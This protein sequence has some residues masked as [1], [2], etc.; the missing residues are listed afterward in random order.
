MKLADSIERHKI[1][2]EFELRPEIGLLILELLA[3]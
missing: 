1:S 3:L 2:D